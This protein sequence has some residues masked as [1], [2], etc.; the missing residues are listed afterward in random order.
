MQKK[1]LAIVFK[2]FLLLLFCCYVDHVILIDAFITSSLDWK[3]A[4]GLQLWYGQPATSSFSQVVAAFEH[5]V[6]KGHAR[7]PLPNYKPYKQYMPQKVEVRYTIL[8]RNKSLLKIRST[9]TK[10][11]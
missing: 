5:A 4:I 9:T 6:V 7:K 10:K 11:K 3:R 1:K 8:E 2:H